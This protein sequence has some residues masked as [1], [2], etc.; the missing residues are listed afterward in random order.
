MAGMANN[1]ASCAE[2]ATSDLQIGPDWQINMELCDIINMDPGQ[3]KE[4]LKVLD[5]LGKNCGESIFQPELRV[6]ERSAGINFPPR[7]ENSVPLFTPPQTQPI[8]RSAPSHEEAAIQA[9]LQSDTSGLSMPEIRT[10]KGLADVL[11]EMLAALDP[12]NSEG[13]KQELIVDLVEQCRNYQTRVM[14]LVNNTADEELLCQGLALND[15]LQRV[16]QRHDDIAIGVAIPG[17]GTALGPVMNVSHEEDE[18]ED[19]FAGLAHRSGKDGM[20]GLSRRTPNPRYV[21]G[22][23]QAESSQVNPLIPPPP[24]SKRPVI[25]ESSTIDYLSGEAYSYGR[26]SETTEPPL[27]SVPSHNSPSSTLPFTPP[28]YEVNTNSPPKFS[29]NPIYD[30][31]N[32]ANQSEQLPPAPWDSS[33]TGNLPPPPS[34]HTQRQQFFNEP[35]SFEGNHP[36]SGS[37]SSYDSL[38][39]QT[40][41]LS[42]NPS[43]PPKEKPEDVLFKDLLDLAK[44]KPST[45][46]P[47]SNNYRSF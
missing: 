7:E 10:A 5:T 9:S 45:S 19:E 28:S 18:S 17:P 38:V 34:K 11:N 39:G 43:N 25:S 22:T 8:I 33:S 41:N 24:V 29:T 37:A 42:M 13:V 16:L 6:K 4:A 14:T 32:P 23:L 12:K 40:Q 47:G 31:P 46:K 15:D 44:F 2:R 21:P 35:P 26:S 3:A 30:E 20:Q 36:S 27:Y 1:A